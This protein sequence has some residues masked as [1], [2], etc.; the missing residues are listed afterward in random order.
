MKTIDKVSSVRGTV[1]APPSK[2]YTAR[3]L[4]L[5][6]MSEGETRIVRPLD[7][8][9]SR[10]MLEAIKK[11]GYE[12]AGTFDGGLTIGERVGISANDVEL[13][14]GNAGTTMRFLT[15]VLAFTP[16]RFILR[17]EERMHERPI[18]DLV[19]A[20]LRIGTEVEYLER[21]GYPPLRIRGR[22]MR[23]GFEVELDGS[24]SSQF[25]SAM[26]MAGATLSGGIRI[27]VRGL[28]SRPY[29][30][31]TRSILRSFGGEVD[32]PEP[33][34]F[35]VHGSRLVRSEYE[36]EGDYSSAS[37]WFAA[38]AACG[39]SVTV[40]GLQPE[41]AQ[42][43]AAFLDILSDLG[44]VIDRRGGSVTITAREQLRGGSFDCNGTP[45]I[46]PTLAAIAPLA[47]HSIEITG[48]PT[49]RVKESDRIASVATAL[50][51]LGAVAHEREDGIV[52]EPGWNERPAVIDPH[53]DHRIAMAFAIAGLARGNVTIGDE[54]VVSKSYP[55]F[56]RDL[57]QLVTSSERAT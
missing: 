45:D 12:V 16:G 1:C 15:G 38:A 31:V 7:S 42:G 11:I 25:V 57:D 18:G 4:L 3:A 51:A 29:V 17:G 34:V 21:E 20:L 41:S 24:T 52:I 6:A 36:V 19:D 14:V 44:A 56:W 47:S 2:S 50:G 9:D 27:R 43:D 48:V 28:S 22:I 49:L 33:D 54:R 55:R 40:E 37:Y 53:G 5:A 26:M 23:G 8:D 46:V 35:H 30:E 39:G 32:E 10:Y 13:H